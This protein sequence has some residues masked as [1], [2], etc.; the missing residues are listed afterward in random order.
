MDFRDSS[1]K[2]HVL[3]NQ[4][5]LVG[6]DLVI[7]TGAHACDHY[8]PFIPD[9]N[10]FDDQ[11]GTDNCLHCVSFCFERSLMG[12]LHAYSY[13]WQTRMIGHIIWKNMLTT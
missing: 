1:E 8:Y 10:H 13:S 9:F 3:L 5:G 12:G 2:G 11:L 6:P 4:I 7:C